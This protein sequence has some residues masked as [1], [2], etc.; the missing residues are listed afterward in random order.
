MTNLEDAFIRLELNP[1]KF[2]SPKA[3]IFENETRNKELPSSFHE[4]FH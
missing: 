3:N 1:E 4:S 2:T